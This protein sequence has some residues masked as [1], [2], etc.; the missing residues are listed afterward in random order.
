MSDF[1]VVSFLAKF[2][3]VFPSALISLFSN[4]LI[5]YKY[6]ITSADVFL[7]PFSVYGFN[8]VVNLLKLRN[9]L[10]SRAVRG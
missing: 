5:E 4:N 1:G 8:G 2:C 7:K 10:F 6:L 3:A 9:M